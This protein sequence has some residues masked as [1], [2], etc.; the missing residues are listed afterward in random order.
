MESSLQTLADGAGEIAEMGTV[1]TC[2]METRLLLP[3]AAD[4]DEERMA[5]ELVETSSFEQFK[6][7]EGDAVPGELTGLQLQN[8]QCL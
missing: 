2:S 6:I 1:V 3:P 5:G 7:G 8:R 4:A